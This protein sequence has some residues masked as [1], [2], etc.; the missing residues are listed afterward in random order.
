MADSKIY[1][2]KMR[3]I[4]H[5]AGKVAMAGIDAKAGTHQLK[6]DDSVLTETDLKI[7]SLIKE[8]LAEFLKDPGHILID[9]EQE[10]R[11]DL[12]DQAKLEAAPFAW[13]IDPIDGTRAF[14]NGMPL[15]GISL[16]LLKDLKPWLGFVYFPALNE[17]FFADGQRA[18]FV[19]DVF[20]AN[21][22]EY[23]IGPV[24]QQLSQQA[25]FFGHER[26]F[27]EFNWDFDLCR[28]ILPACA[29]IDLCWPAVGRG[30]GSMFKA[31]LW[32]MAG[33]WPIVK[34][35]GMDFR[36]VETGE[37]MD[38]IRTDLFIGEG[39]QTWKF[40]HHYIISSPRNFPFLR[41]SVL[42]S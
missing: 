8:E 20:G 16:G 41:K 30:C 15:F 6:D 4:A 1:I 26:F 38:R 24:D 9:E 29:V 17:A 31:N 10:N 11:E 36:V 32:D 25:V 33:S 19:R 28:V 37:V 39:I 3:H 13:V 21:E 34:A 42:K 7:S 5:Q 12:F 18:V 14:S 40:K 22:R 2:K 27:T 23:E 35:A